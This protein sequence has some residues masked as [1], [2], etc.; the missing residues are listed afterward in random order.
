MSGPLKEV[1]LTVRLS[2]THRQGVIA[3]GNHLNLTPS[4]VVR[5]ALAEFLDRRWAELPGSKWW[6]N[7]NAS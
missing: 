2:R 6:A 5:L 7:Q 1:R 3:I 4:G